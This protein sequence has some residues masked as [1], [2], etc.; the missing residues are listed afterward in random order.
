[1]KSNLGLDFIEKRNCMSDFKR[2]RTE[3]QKKQ[4]MQE[5]KNAVDELFSEKP[6][7]EIT[8]TVIV[9][10]LHSTRANLYLYYS[11]KEEIFLELCS[12]KR[13]LYYDALKAAFPKGSQY[14][15]ETIAAVWANILNAHTD[16]L[17]YS[18][19]LHTIIETNVAVDRLAT[20]KK[21]YYEKSFEVARQ[22][23]SL[24]ELST[25]DAY[26]L[27]INIHYHAVGIYAINR[28]NPLIA[29]VLEQENIKTPVFE[30]R[31]ELTNYILI[32]LKHY[33]AQ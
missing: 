10:K 16:Y 28:W 17:H 9:D 29:E 26:H 30:F 15:L 21:R 31:E 12:D 1:M 25:D 19:I 6:Y 7:H 23:G 13:D 4:R 32:M 22:I 18:D 27:L 8:L 2:A 5:I 14:T 24:L 3:T 20:Y 11:T 33:S